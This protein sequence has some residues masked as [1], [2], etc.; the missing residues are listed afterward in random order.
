MTLTMGTGPFGHRPSGRF[1]FEVP[2][3]RVLYV[4]P[5][6]RRMRALVGGET[7][8]NSRR[9]SLLYE[10]RRL[11][12]LYFPEDDV[13]KE[14]VDDAALTRRDELPELQ[15]LVSLDWNAADEWFDEDESAIG[16]VRDPYHRIEVLQTSRHVVV[17]LEG[18]TLAET[19]R[20]IGL[21]EAGLPTRWYI[22]REDVR[23]DLLEESETMT[24]CAYKGHASHYSAQAGDD[25]AWTYREPLHEVDRVRNLIAFYNERV[26][27]DVDGE[28]QERP[29]TPWSR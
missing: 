13:R 29:Q 15:G 11:P 10:Q 5:F 7:V 23:M 3:E 2:S 14:L 9:G 18:E 25:V 12:L 4:D 20:P 6:P 28:R 26:D 19:N 22:P 17:S 27:L 8:I 16:H 1:N 21:F 24:T